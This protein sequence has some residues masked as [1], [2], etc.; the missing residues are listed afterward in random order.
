MCTLSPVPHATQRLASNVYFLEVGYTQQG[1]MLGQLRGSLN[2]SYSFPGYCPGL[3]AFHNFCFHF[4]EPFSHTHDNQ[5]NLAQVL[6][7]G[8]LL[9]AVLGSE[10]GN[11]A[12]ME[13]GNEAAMGSEPGN[14]AAMGSEPGN[15]AAIT[16]VHKVS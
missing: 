13:P 5:E 12:A 6:L 15:E 7:T 3:H 14:E 10:P 4:K 2:N 1:M 11:E 16:H 9:L 8:S